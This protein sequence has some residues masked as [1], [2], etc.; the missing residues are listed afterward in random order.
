VYV[1]NT[2]VGTGSGNIYMLVYVCIYGCQDNSE[3]ATG[4]G[5]RYMLVGLCMYA[6]QRLLQELETDICW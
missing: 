3:V 4:A 1:C 5:N 2:E 6:I